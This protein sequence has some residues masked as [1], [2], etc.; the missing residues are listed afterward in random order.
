[1]TPGMRLFVLCMALCLSFAARAQEGGRIKVLV[2]DVETKD[3]RPGEVET[4][5]SLITAHLARY[6]QL[7][8]LSGAD[9]KR[10]VD[11]EAQKQSAGCDEGSCLSE[12]A[13]AIGAQLVFFGQA[14]KLGGTIVVTL[15]VFDAAKGQ[16]VG[17]QPIEARDLGQ[18]PALVG[19]AIDNMVRPLF[20]RMRGG[21]IGDA[22]P[23]GMGTLRADPSLNLTTRAREVYAEKEM[24]VCVDEDDRV[25]WWFC[26]KRNRYTENEFIRDYKKVTRS[27]DL[28]KFEQ[29][30]NPEGLALPVGLIAGGAGVAV[31]IGGPF[32][33]LTYVD[34]S[35]VPA[36]SQDSGDGTPLGGAIALSAIVV[37]G[38][39]AVYGAILVPSALEFTD[40]A[41]TDH[42]MKE[43]KAREAAGKYNAALAESIGKEYGTGP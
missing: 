34:S 23:G 37:G 11:L 43:P 3:L 28:D 26:D 42:S 16:A 21:A 32:L 7:D 18:L 13:G 39:M 40:G 30:R 15:N 10:L 2:L 36:L 1:M 24:N 6:P 5:T 29:N 9:I 8:V 20:E 27:N 14:G 38:A 25:K 35:I 12:I 31:L 19:P 33:Y 17:R 41:P 22:P 4:L